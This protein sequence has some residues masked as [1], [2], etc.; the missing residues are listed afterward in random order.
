MVED[1]PTLFWSVLFTFVGSCKFDSS[2]QPQEHSSATSEIVQD[3]HS[4]KK[5]ITDLSESSSAVFWDR[6]DE[7][8]STALQTIYC[9]AVVWTACTYGAKHLCLH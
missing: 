7:Y 9:T 8:C 6:K 5:K 3:A 2:K 1:W 4:V